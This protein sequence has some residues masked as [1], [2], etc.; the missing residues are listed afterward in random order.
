MIFNIVEQLFGYVFKVFND[1]LE[2]FDLLTYLK[3]SYFINALLVIIII[4]N[5]II[6]SKLIMIICDYSPSLYSL[7]FHYYLY[8][9]CSVIC[10]C[11]TG[12][13]GEGEVC[14]VCDARAIWNWS[15]SVTM[16][17][18]R[19]LSTPQLSFSC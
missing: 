9:L 14:D 12:R 19:R 2:S 10:L 8:Y 3:L 4:I 17:R 7:Y 5:L 15:L 18:G 13:V 16:I 11:I 1:F 6:I